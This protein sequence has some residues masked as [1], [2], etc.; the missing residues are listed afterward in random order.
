MDDLAAGGCTNASSL[1]QQ[2]A[3]DPWSG[4]A[5]E[6][7]AVELLLGERTSERLVA[8]PPSRRRGDA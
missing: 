6:R 4:K 8:P 5:L 2:A 7:E 1:S 3:G